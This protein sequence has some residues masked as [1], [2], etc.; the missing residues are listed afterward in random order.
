MTLGA[1]RVAGVS[2]QVRSLLLQQEA[3]QLHEPQDQ[4]QGVMSVVFSWLGLLT[5]QNGNEASSHILSSLRIHAPIWKELDETSGVLLETTPD[6]HLLHQTRCLQVIVSLN[7]KTSP[8][9]KIQFRTRT[10]P[11]PKHTQHCQV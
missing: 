1:L 4:M 5:C 2:N 7:M 8:A 11:N 6:H 3:E 10:T 9:A